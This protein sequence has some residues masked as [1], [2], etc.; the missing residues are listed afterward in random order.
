MSRHARPFRRAWAALLACLASLAVC[1]CACAPAAPEEASPSPTPAVER[2]YALVVKD[3]TNPYM[4]RMFSGFEEACV[5][6]GA[7][8]VLAG[9]EDISA[10]GQIACIEELIANGI[11]AIAIAA[12]DRD[13]LSPVLQSALAAGVK[14]VSLDSDVNP[15]DR[16]VHIQQASPEVIGRVLMQAAREM[17]GAEGAFAILTT[18]DSASNQALWVE[19]MLREIEENPDQYGKM[20]LVDTLFG[21]DL[22]EP[23]Y[24]LVKALMD[25]HPETAIVIAPTSVGILAAAD[26]IHDAGASTLVTGLGLPSDMGDYIRDGLCPWMYLWN[27]IDVGYVAACAAD[28][29]VCGEISGAVGE[30]LSAGDRGILKI[31]PAADG[32]S[33]IVVGNPYM[34]DSSNVAVWEEIF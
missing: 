31:T 16:L 28:A 19:W 7:Q 15:Q 32:G 22:Y 23:S 33:E 4:Q 8:A 25:E 2:R 3:V 20:T 5:S 29:L 24:E 34:F 17:I 9:S 11:D 12:N 10:E 18:T 14:V 1:L 13:A 30:V 21:L 6:L 26:A 27:P